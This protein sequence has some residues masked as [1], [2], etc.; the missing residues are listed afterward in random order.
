MHAAPYIVDIELIESEYKV[1]GRSNPHCIKSA[2]NRL[3]DCIVNSG[4]DTKFSGA[5]VNSIL[6]SNQCVFCANV[7]DCRAI[8]CKFDG[9]SIFLTRN[10]CF[11]AFK[12][13][14]TYEHCRG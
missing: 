14:Q 2:Y 1:Q 4:I 3:N 5:T 10:C 9:S 8:L 12:R 13:P 11:S 7:G 6:I